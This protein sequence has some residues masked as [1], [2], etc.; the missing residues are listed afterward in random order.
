METKRDPPQAQGGCVVAASLLQAAKAIKLTGRV[1]RQFNMISIGFLALLS[2]IKK[3][4]PSHPF[5][6]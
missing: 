3:F 2:Q 6:K 5:Q 4:C 1:E